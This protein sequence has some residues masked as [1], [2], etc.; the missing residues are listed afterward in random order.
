L[1]GYFTRSEEFPP[2]SVKFLLERARSH[3]TEM[4][5]EF[6]VAQT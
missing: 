1:R 5:D 4:K 2:E 3:R 6:T